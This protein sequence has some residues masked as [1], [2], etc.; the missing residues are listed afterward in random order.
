M[1]KNIDWYGESRWEGWPTTCVNI[2]R[3]N[4]QYLRSRTEF[5]GSEN[6]FHIPNAT[7][8]SYKQH[9]LIKGASLRYALERLLFPGLGFPL[10]PPFIFFTEYP[11]SSAAD[12]ASLLLPNL[13]FPPNPNFSSFFC[14][15]LAPSPLALRSALSF[16]AVVA[17]SSSA[18]SKGSFSLVAR[19]AP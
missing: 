19:S 13:F 15:F 17:A 1:S 16:A 12:L 9:S 8:I 4:D 10:P 18:T 6:H 3:T 7:L 11:L 5:H 2:T 14:L